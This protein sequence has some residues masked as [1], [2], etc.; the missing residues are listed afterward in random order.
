[1]RRILIICG[2]LACL[3]LAGCGIATPTQGEKIG[4]IIKVNKE[5]LFCTTWEVQMIRGGMSD[6]SGGFGVTP[7]N[8]TVENDA[9]AEK[10]IQYMKNQTEV[11]VRYRAPFIYS[12][13]N[14]WSGGYFLV[15][16]EPA[17]K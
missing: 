4:V 17:K 10:V 8:F 15:S 12:P 5:G 14:T 1:M 13:C 9:A 3:T 16:I 11:V 6:G 7:F 2:T